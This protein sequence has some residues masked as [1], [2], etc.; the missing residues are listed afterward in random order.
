MTF[1]ECKRK[2]ILFRNRFDDYTTGFFKDLH[3]FT[4]EL[5]DRDNAPNVSCVP[6]GDYV[7]RKHNSPK[8]G[9]CLKVFDKDGVSEVSGRSEIL[10]H[11]GN[12]TS[13]TEGCILPCVKIS[14]ETGSAFGENS[15]IALTTLISFVGD[16]DVGLTIRSA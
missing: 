3:V 7:I 9:K 14:F 11:A 12:T 10:I 2:M 13:D 8:F 6:F 15:K 5:P 4:V 16:D 1:N